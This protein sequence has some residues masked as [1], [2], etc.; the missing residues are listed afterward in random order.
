M[1]MDRLSSLTVEAMAEGKPTPVQARQDG[2]RKGRQCQETPINFTHLICFLYL[3]PSAGNNSRSLALFYPILI[4][5]KF[6]LLTLM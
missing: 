6:P 5:L 4:F 2:P 1:G 3:I